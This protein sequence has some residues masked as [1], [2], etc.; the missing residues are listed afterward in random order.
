MYS[1]SIARHRR[2]RTTKAFTLLEIMVVVVII[3]LLA[4]LVTVR[5]R[6]YLVVS[7]QNAAKVEIA[8]MVEALEAYYAVHNRYPTNEEGLAAL[9]EKTQ[10]FPDGLLNKVPKDPWGNDYVYNC[11]GQ[12]EVFEI[13]CFGADGQEGGESENADIK[14]GQ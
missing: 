6:S 4:G 10:S 3:G 9:V 14:S 7:K 8:K 11:P 1:K 12:T 5:T 2:C 13:V